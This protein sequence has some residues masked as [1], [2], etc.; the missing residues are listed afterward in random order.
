MIDICGKYKCV[1]DTLLEILHD[2]Q[3][4]YGNIPQT[5]YKIIAGQLNLS[6]AEVYG[7]EVLPNIRTVSDV[8]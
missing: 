2:I 4:F 5:A 8:F 1:P 7:V 3:K 6:R